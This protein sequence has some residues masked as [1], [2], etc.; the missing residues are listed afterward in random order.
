MPGAEGAVRKMYDATLTIVVHSRE[1]GWAGSRLVRN[2]DIQLARRKHSA[3]RR[4]DSI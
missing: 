3:Q 1:N 2:L 4:R